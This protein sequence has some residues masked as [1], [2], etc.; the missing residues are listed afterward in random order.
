[1]LPHAL[2]MLMSSSVET[3]QRDDKDPGFLN[4]PT[5]HASHTTTFQ[6]EIIARAYKFAL[7]VYLHIILDAVA[8]SVPSHASLLEYSHLR[9]LIVMTK[10]GAL[11]ACIQDMLLV[12]DGDPYVVGLV[13]LLFVV[14]SE[15][16]IPTQFQSAVAKLTSILQS[17]CLGHVGRTLEL[18]QKMQ[19]INSLSWR[20]I[21]QCCEWDLIVT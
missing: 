12:S 16:K 10:D 17:S 18:L 5:H 2:P 14:A 6:L 15:T 9:K 3:V 4:S 1:M 21:L 20:Q 7:V 19:R 8:N 13:P 11:S